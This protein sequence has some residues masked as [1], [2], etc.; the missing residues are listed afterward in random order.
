MG[1]VVRSLDMAEG[2]EGL[3]GLEGV[4]GQKAFKLDEKKVGRTR[5]PSHELSRI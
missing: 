1:D 4:G 3:E 5:R 2:L